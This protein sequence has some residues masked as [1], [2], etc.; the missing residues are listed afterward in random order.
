MSN[1]KVKGPSKEK[2]ALIEEIL[3]SFDFDRVRKVMELL[4]WTYVIPYEDDYGKKSF[5]KEVP[6][7][8][9]IIKNAKALLE[10]AYDLKTTSSTA[11]FTAKYEEDEDGCLLLLWFT[12]E[13]VGVESCILS[14][15][16]L[17]RTLI[18]S[19]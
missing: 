4:D 2:D 18:D 16:T 5:K 17:A 1:E 15:G 7:T 8:Q 6:K 11:G 3:E 19:K 9:Y 13:E 12:L 10:E 14:G